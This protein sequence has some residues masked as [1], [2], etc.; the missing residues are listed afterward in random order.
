[1]R[2]RDFYRHI[3]PINDFSLWELKLSKTGSLPFSA[4]KDHQVRYL[5]RS[6]T[7]VGV[8]IKF[9]DTGIQ[10]PGADG[11]WI[12]NAP[13]AWVIVL[14]WKPYKPI[15]FYYIDIDAW[16]AERDTTPR[17]SLLE[18]RAAE[19]GTRIKVKKKHGA[20]D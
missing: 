11:I 20:K 18:A 8:F 5:Q 9:P 10:Q 15:V 19:I 13:N 3:I 7:E 12:R 6:K 1:M 16:C 2:E 14:F 17:K 4:L